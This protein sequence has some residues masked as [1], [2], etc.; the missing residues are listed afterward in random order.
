[1]KKWMLISLFLFCPLSTHAQTTITVDLMQARLVWEWAQGSGGVVEAFKLK[2]GPTS[3]TYPTVVSFPNPAARSAPV[4]GIILKPGTYFC[5]IS[6]MNI[7]G[8]SSNSNEVTFNAGTVPIAPT[9]LRI[10]AN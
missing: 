10:S 9:N 1:M 6:A 2:C 7:F 4:S 3:G 8:E 5:V